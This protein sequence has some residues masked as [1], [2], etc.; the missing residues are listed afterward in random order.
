MKNLKYLFLL[1]GLALG[2]CTEQKE[3]TVTEEVETQDSASSEVVL[4]K[5]QYANLDVTLGNAESRMMSSAI[6]A[7]GMVDVPPENIA[8]VSTVVNGK[9]A[10]ITHNVLPGKYVKKGSV[11][12]LATSTELLDI[13]Q[14][15]LESYLKNDFLKKELVRQQQL[16]TENAG[17]EKSLQ[18]AQNNLKMNEAVLAGLE[19][20]LKL[21]NVDLAS[22]QSGKIQEQFYVYSPI[23]GYVKEVFINTGSNFSPTDVLFELISNEH[24]HV[25]LQ[26]FEKDAMYLKEGQKVML[27]G[28]GLSGQ[29]EGSVFLIA[30]VFDDQSKAI[31]V[32]VH[33][34][35]HNAREA[36]IPGQFL[37]GEIQIDEHEV[38]ALPE[39]SLLREPDGTYIL[40][41]KSEG[42]EII[43]EKM[44]VETGAV[45]NGWAEIITP[46]SFENIVTKGA[47]LFAGMAGEEK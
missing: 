43:F 28:A 11:L 12:A 2:A 24:L 31:R 35:D 46:G 1:A 30:K 21:S 32:H 13:Q 10:R 19:A 7:N 16:I 9:I 20:K 23:S 38:K 22:L 17:V 33:L 41:L 15:Y 25:E 34:N 42:E 18:S 6:T 47:Q 37:T 26:V 40:K 5:T 27:S 14:N 36:L 45:Q 39:S 4:T 29:T 8:K 44:E 3:E